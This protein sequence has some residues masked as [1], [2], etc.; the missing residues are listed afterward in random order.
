MDTAKNLAVMPKP[1]KEAKPRRERG[2]GGLSQPFLHANPPSEIWYAKVNGKRRSTGT[3]IKQEALGKLQKMQGRTAFNMPDPSDLKK[4]RYEEGRALVLADYKNEDAA[5]LVTKSD[6]TVTVWGLEHVDAFFSGRPVVDINAEVL[7]A[8]VD[9][10]LKD[11]ASPSTVNRNLALLRRMLNL[12]ARDKDIKV[13]H[14]PHLKEPDA[15]QGFLENDAF[16]KLFFALPERLRAFVLFLYTTGCRSGEAKKLRWSQV[17]LAE[18]VISVQAEQTKNRKARTIPLCDELVKM[19]NA[20]PKAKR[21][22]LLFPVGTFRKAWQSACVKAG[23]GTLDK[24]SKVNGGYG[25]YSGLIPH[26]LRRSAVRNLRKAGF[27]EVLAM[28]ISGHKTN[29]VFKRYDITDT[30]EKVQAVAEI[31]SSLGQVLKSAKGR[32]S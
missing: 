1:K 7:Q 10:R 4:I 24:S 12:L 15:R 19:L 20:T 28:S 13:P 9:R 11:G 5:S 8:F 6:G 21:V 22:G 31:G 16:A 3:T 14:F 26:D 2:S 17:S 27:G 23:L 29:E 25:L 18:K 32:K 30:T